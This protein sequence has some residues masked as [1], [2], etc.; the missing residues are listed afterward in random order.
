MVELK[1]GTFLV[2]EMVQ[3]YENS[4]E[5]IRAQGKYLPL[6]QPLPTI[7]SKQ[8]SMINYYLS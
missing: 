6:I 5:Y 1:E 4:G 8:P 2:L 7:V 3:E